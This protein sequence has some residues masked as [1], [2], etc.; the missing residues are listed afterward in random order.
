MTRENLHRR[1]QG[2]DRPPRR[3]RRT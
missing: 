1:A 2:C 3:R